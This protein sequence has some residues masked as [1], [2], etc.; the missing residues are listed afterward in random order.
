ML[1]RDIGRRLNGLSI[2]AVAV[3]LMV[4]GCTSPTMMAGF[5]ATVKEPPGE[6]YVLTQLNSRLSFPV[7][8]ED[9]LIVHKGEMTVVWILLANDKEL[10]E[11]RAISQAIPPWRWLMVRPV[12]SKDLS[13]LRKKQ[14]AG[15]GP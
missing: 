8:S 2:A 6:R 10:A 13:V 3:L 5:S 1:R 7:E 15:N 12:S 11:L 9:L 4:T 14:R